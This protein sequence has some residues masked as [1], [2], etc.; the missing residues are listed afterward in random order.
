[1]L[2]NKKKQTNIYIYIYIYMLFILTYS[3]KA[4]SIKNGSASSVGLFFI[5]IFTSRCNSVPKIV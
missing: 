3:A 2:T 1:M 5:L 4:V